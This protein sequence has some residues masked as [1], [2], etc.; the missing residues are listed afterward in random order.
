MSRQPRPAAAGD[1]APR[2]HHIDAIAH[3]F[4]SDGE[5][6]QPG[7][8]TCVVRDVA[9]A[10]PGSGRAAACAASG[11]AAVAVGD[12]GNC[13]V[14]DETVAWSAFSYL[15]GVKP[16]ALPPVAAADL[17]PGVRARWLGG[18]GA[19]TAGP[20]PHRW[21]RWRLLGEAS[22]ATLP[23]WEV[24]CGLPPAARAAT[25]R[26]SALV[27]C[28][29]VGEAAQPEPAA[30]L[31]RLVDL[32]RPDRVEFLV[33]PDAWETPPGGWRLVGRR[34]DPGWRN[35]AHLQDVARSAAGD[36]PASVRVFPDEP[37]AAGGAGAA[38]L[39]GIAATIAGFGDASRCG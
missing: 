21:L 10:A 1:S 20:L 14:E 19:S 33:V 22:A 38:L 36:V 4:L 25:P 18:I 7:A 12:W 28:V 29:G 17:P 39:A 5:P 9:V 11:L 13:L 30:S 16:P 31:R 34:R 37:A 26:W 6:A 24:A 15:G 32:L 23:A 2:V 8:V 27:W 3:H 35:L